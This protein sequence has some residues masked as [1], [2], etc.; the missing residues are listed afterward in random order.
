MNNSIEDIAIIIR[1]FI[2]ENFLFGYTQED[3]SN[4]TSFLEI[5]VLDSTGIIELVAFL[6]DKF[7]INFFDNEIIPENLDTINLMAD[8]V[9]K[10]CDEKRMLMNYRIEDIV[11]IIRK[12]IFNNFQHGASEKDI[13]N[14]TSFLEIGVLD[15]TGIIELVSFLE[16]EFE[17]EFHD[18]EIIPENLDTINLMADFVIRKHKNSGDKV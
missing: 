10:K 13:G 3:L 18:D 2:F 11:L 12:Y 8:F 16:E 1:N 14:D 7:D 4:D 15:S 5:G 17:I 9:M 6:E